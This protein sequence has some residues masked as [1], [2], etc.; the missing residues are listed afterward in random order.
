VHPA[1]SWVKGRV[2]ATRTAPFALREG[3][4]LVFLL[5]GSEEA[6]ES[7]ARFVFEDDGFREDAVTETVARGGEFALRGGGATGFGAVGAGGEDAA[8]GAHTMP[9]CAWLA[10]GSFGDWLGRVFSFS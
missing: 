8:L 7:L 4:R 1:A 3:L 6:D 2:R 5:P 9:H 10:G